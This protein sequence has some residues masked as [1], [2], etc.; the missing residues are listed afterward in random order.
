LTHRHRRQYSSTIDKRKQISINESRPAVGTLARGLD[1]L[2]LFPTAG[3]DLSQTEISEALE[4]PLPTVHRLTTVLTERGFL[5]RDAESRRLRLGLEVT[6]LIP[7]LLTGMRLPELARRHLI[8]LVREVHE[9]ANLAVL[10]GNQIVYLLSEPGDRLLTLQATVGQRLPGHC[11]ALGK[12]LLAHLSEDAARRALGREPYEARTPH[13]ITSWMQMRSTLGEIRR[14]GVSRS[15][16]EF[17][18]GLVSIAVPVSWTDGRGSAA[19]N[20]SLPTAR[21]TRQVRAELEVRLGECADAIGAAARVRS[22]GDH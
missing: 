1:I 9:T 13:T 7:P 12:C 15:E 22:P 3:G 10:D 21:A 20:V 14:T 19:I 6:R 11:T 5:D 16:E 18:I 4:L 8:S 17:E 2:T